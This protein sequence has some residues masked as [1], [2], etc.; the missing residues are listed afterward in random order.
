MDD[1]SNNEKIGGF[2]A[3]LSVIIPGMI[4]SDFMPEWNV[5]PF[6]VW[7]SI[8]GVG[9]AIGAAIATKRFFI[10]SV[11]G[12]IAG[13]GAIIGVYKYVDIR[14]FFTGS[15]VFLIFELVLAAAIGSAPGF[16]LYLISVKIT[17][18]DESP[19]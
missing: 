18:S 2:I 9:S 5:L 10:G 8:A 11:C 16:I 4:V 13:V 7:L 17:A 6:S 1:E 14:L 15:D 19:N 12:A 3:I